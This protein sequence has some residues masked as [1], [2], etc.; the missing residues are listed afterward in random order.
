M[1]LNEAGIQADKQ[2]HPLRCSDQ[3]DADEQRETGNVGYPKLQ[4]GKCVRDANG[5]L[6][7][8]PS[9]SFNKFGL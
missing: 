4:A 3:R 2:V 8:P 7:L 5:I 6:K 1:I 9:S